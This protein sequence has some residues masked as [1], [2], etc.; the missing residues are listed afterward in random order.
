MEILDAAE[1]CLVVGDDLLDFNLGGE[2]SLAAAAAAFGDESLS[3]SFPV[4]SVHRVFMFDTVP[5]TGVVLLLSWL[6]RV[7]SLTRWLRVSG[8]SPRAA[9]V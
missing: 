9:L 3:G 7:G 4:S 5:E 8:F 1:V 2:A 6:G